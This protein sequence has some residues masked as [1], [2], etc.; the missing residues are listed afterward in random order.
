[1]F[2][3]LGLAAAEQIDFSRLLLGEWSVHLVEL[4]SPPTQLIPSMT[5]EFHLLN[6]SNLTEGTVWRDDI[7]TPDFHPIETFFLAHLE[8]D[9]LSPSS[10]RIYTMQ[11]ERRLLSNTE[12]VS[13]TSSN[14]YTSWIEIGD[15][16]LL[17]AIPES[18]ISDASIHGTASVSL[19]GLG[20]FTYNLDRA[21]VVPGTVATSYESWVVVGGVIVALHVLLFLILRSCGGGMVET[22]QAGASGDPQKAKTD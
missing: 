2:L 4:N 12:F 20:T 19:K 10:A 11:P 15:W 7:D 17:I 1:M 3:L 22:D 8:V 14:N 9:W 21:P 5:F 13:N 16:Q 18:G 6:N